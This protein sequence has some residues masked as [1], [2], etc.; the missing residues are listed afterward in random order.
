MSL[1]YTHSIPFPNLPNLSLLPKQ[2]GLTNPNPN[3]SSQKNVNPNPFI[4]ATYA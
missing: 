2:P 3:L 4:H 1:E